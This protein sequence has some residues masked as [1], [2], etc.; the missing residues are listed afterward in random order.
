MIEH[1]P[2]F[3]MCGRPA[4]GIAYGDPW[5]LNNRFPAWRCRRCWYRE[6]LKSGHWERL[7]ERILRRSNW[8]CE[9]CGE[10][11]GYSMKGNKIGLQVHHLS[12]E[13]VGYE[14]DDDLIVLCFACH[15]KEHGRS[16]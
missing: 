13:R 14:H 10:R 6:Y 1:F 4:T 9:R 11:A 8:K 7:R 15:A 12:Y 3:A 16:A 5:G 2:D